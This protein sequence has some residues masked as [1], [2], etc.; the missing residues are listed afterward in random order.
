MTTASHTR[1]LSALEEEL[2]FVSRSQ[3]EDILQEV[4]SHLCDMA[5]R[6]GE[7]AVEAAIAGY[8]SPRAYAERLMEAYGLERAL[9]EP[10]A[11]R[12]FGATL[13]YAGRSLGLLCGAFVSFVFGA[14]ALAFLAIAVVEL[15]APELTGLFVGDDSGS[16]GIVPPA[17]SE[18]I[19]DPLGLWILPIALL[20][21]L[22][23]AMFAVWILRVSLK[24]RLRSIRAKA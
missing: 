4:D 3:R 9:S 2:A 7:A 18:G 21:T 23:S 1:F 17:V 5:E 10:G 19:E 16:F 13:V 22:L 11:G 6:G 20:G 14:I 24:I 12:L 8:G 15:A